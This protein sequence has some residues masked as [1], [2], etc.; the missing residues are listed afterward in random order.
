MP[1]TEIASAVALVLGVL[2]YGFAG[3]QLTEGSRAAGGALRSTAWWL[4]V[5]LQGCGFLLTFAARY[6][7]PLL[8]VQ[9]CVVAALAVTAV[10]RHRTGR[11]QLTGTDLAA[12][13]GLVAA[14]AVVAT[15]TVPGQVASPGLPHLAVLAGLAGVTAAGLLLPANLT[16][17]LTAAVHGSLS[18]IGFGFSAIGAR[19]LIA[20]AA[21]PPW[22]VAQLPAASWLVGVAVVAGLGLGQWHL[23]R[24]LARGPSTGTLGAMYFT[25]TLVPALVGWTLLGESTRP[26]TDWIILLAMAVGGAGSAV[27]LRAQPEPVAP[28]APSPTM[29]G[30]TTGL[31]SGSPYPPPGRTS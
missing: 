1:A 8:L 24:G 31:T 25:D 29:P 30:P 11:R 10:I 2:S 17:T 9:S 4:G 19:L 23:T 18:G 7:M 6:A 5:V 13:A 3:A 12:I 16:P 26:G 20:D 15:T 22:R 28:T 14:V 27:L 21:H